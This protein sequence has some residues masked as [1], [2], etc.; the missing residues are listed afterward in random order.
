MSLPK[1]FSRCNIFCAVLF[2]SFFVQ[3]HENHNNSSTTK[4]V[5][6]NT[7]DHNK[8]L[9]NSYSA[10]IN[11]QKTVTI[12]K[13]QRVKLNIAS[14][15]EE[16]IEDCNTSNLSVVSNPKEGILFPLD[17]Q[18]SAIYQ[19]AGTSNIVDEILFSHTNSA[20][21]VTLFSVVIEIENTSTKLMI[22]SPASNFQTSKRFVTVSYKVTGNNFDHI[23]LSINDEEHSS[24]YG[25]EGSY[26]F[27]NVPLGKNRIDASLA[28]KDHRQITG[29]RQTIIFEVIR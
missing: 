21:H 10:G 18:S 22:L 28:G 13:G 23:H 11:N 26:T 19:H 8:K 20:D 24:I 4:P 12:E 17:A 15:C 25:R 9:N 2:V 27:S 3:A 7:T 14:V 16:F 5:A 6:K 1:V 29:T